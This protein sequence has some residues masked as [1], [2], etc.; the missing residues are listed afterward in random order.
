MPDHPLD[1]YLATLKAAARPRATDRDSGA[2]MEAI[3]QA[4]D[5]MQ[6]D[7]HQHRD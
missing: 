4:I 2:L 5:D 1:D 7:H 3:A 6:H